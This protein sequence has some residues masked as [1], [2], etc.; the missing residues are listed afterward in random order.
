MKPVEKI[1]DNIWKFKTDG[2]CYFL[3]F[4][5]KIMID[6][7]RREHRTILDQ[8]LPKMIRFDEIQKV[9]FTHLHYDHIGNFDLFKNAEFFASEESISDL[10][11][12]GVAAILNEEMAEK[13]DVELKPVRDMNGLKV[14]KTP[15]HTN[16]AICLWYEKELVLFS[17]D[18]MFFNKKLGRTDLP[19]SDPDKM[20]ET[21]MKLMDYNFRTLCPGHEY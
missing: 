5:D 14:I 9:I 21:V 17:G 20:K 2:N 19:L 15:G 12:N 8:F 6:T 13:F 3:N 4:D 1:S 10:K 11:N 7:G 16:G 18:T